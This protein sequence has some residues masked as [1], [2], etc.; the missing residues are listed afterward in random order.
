CKRLL[1]T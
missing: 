1:I